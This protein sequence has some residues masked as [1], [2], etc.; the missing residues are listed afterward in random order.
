MPDSSRCDARA[1][2]RVARVEPVALD[3]SPS[4]VA[5]RAGPTRVRPRQHQRRDC[6]GVPP[7][8]LE[9]KSSAPG[10]AE[11]VR[12]PGAESAKEGCEAVG[13]VRKTK[14]LGWIG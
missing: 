14:R 13:V 10:K 4:F 2:E 12:R 3:L 7:I 11:H 6:A 8:E 9:G 1:G 5:F